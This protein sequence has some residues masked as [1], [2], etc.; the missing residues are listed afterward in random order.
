MDNIQD[1]ILRTESSSIIIPTSNIK[2]YSE[3]YEEYNNNIP[4]YGSY[5]NN[6]PDKQ[7]KY[8]I[9]YSESSN[10]PN[11]PFGK[12]PPNN[13]YFKTAYLNYLASNN[14]KNSFVEN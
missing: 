1:H 6:I 3:S 5:D 2:S 12:S 13:N 8:N 9:R 14:L 10:F 11:K 7:S 4:N